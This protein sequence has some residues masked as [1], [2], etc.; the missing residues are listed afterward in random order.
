MFSYKGIAIPLAAEAGI[1]PAHLRVKAACRTA[2]LLGIEMAAKPLGVNTFILDFAALITMIN[3][4]KIRRFCFYITNG[5]SI[6]MLPLVKTKMLLKPSHY[7]LPLRK[8]TN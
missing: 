3:Y 6:G 1:E 5:F 4:H 8:L 7:I 2:W